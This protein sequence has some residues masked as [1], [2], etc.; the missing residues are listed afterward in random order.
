MRKVESSSLGQILSL[1]YNGIEPSDEFLKTVQRYKIGGVL[2]LSGNIGTKKQISDSI[3]LLQKNSEIPLFVMI[4]QEGGRINRIT[5]NFPQ[6]PSNQFYGMNNDKKGVHAAY[7]QTA[8]ELRKL[9]INVNL[10]PVVDVLTNPSNLVIGDRSFGSDPERVAEFSRIAIQSIKEHD[11]LACA[12]HF[13]GIGDI[14][15]DPHKMLPQNPNSLARF[16]KIDFT[17]FRAA[18]SCEVDFIMSTHVIATELDA[19]SPATF[20]KKICTGILKNELDFKGVLITDDMQMKAIKDNYSLEKVCFLAFEAGNDM[21]LISENLEE[22][23]K[24]LE[25]FEKKFK[26]NELSSSRL[27]ESTSRILSLKA[28]NLKSRSS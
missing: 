10:A 12:K 5:Q 23:L 11:V 21:I 7:S 17:P 28:K 27:L 4:D 6:F 9:G 24:V 25:Y 13:P 22:Q 20:S 19:S 2:L 1:G 3:E 18:I 26:D 15:D 16:Q 14:S 8:R